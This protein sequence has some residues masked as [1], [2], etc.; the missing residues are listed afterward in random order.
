[1][2]SE[3]ETLSSLLAALDEVYLLHLELSAPVLQ[4]AW[5]LTED[6]NRLMEVRNMRV[7]YMHTVTGTQVHMY[8]CVILH[9]YQGL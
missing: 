6:L 2:E 1:M 5:A 3:Y 4:Q 9:V 8:T 7:L